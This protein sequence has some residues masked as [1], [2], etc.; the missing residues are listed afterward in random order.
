M[1]NE[2]E[3]YAELYN[4]TERNLKEK[5]QSLKLP[6]SKE[7]FIYS[8]KCTPGIADIQEMTQCK[9][10]MDFLGIA[11]WSLLFR[12]PDEGA[13]IEWEKLKDLPNQEF[14]KRVIYSLS[15]ST[16]FLVKKCKVINNIFEEDEKKNK[17]NLFKMIIIKL[18]NKSPDKCKIIIKILYKKMKGIH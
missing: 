6:M 14:Q 10:N 3:I 1:F 17:K 12:V 16:E 18:Y 15:S 7:L 2:Q 9:N 5:E 13:V 11:Y 8:T 4:I